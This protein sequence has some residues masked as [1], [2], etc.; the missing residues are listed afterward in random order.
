MKAAPLRFLN[1]A[2]WPLT[3]WSSL[4][5]LEEHPADDY[6]ERTSPIVATAIGFWIC[7]ASLG[8]AIYFSA[9]RVVTFGEGVDAVVRRMTPT[10]TGTAQDILWLITPVLYGIGFWLFT[11]RDTAFPR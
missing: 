3:I 11:A 4:T 7:A 10:W 2:L 5:H 9:G 1:A 6:V 8:A